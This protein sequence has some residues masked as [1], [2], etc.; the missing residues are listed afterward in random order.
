MQRSIK[1]PHEPQNRRLLAHT[2]QLGNINEPHPNQREF[3]ENQ[4]NP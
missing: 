4:R 2:A 3:Q 1:T